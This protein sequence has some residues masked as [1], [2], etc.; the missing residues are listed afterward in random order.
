MEEIWKPIDGYVGKYE[1]SNYGNIRSL[2]FINNVT[3]KEQIHILHP[4]KRN[5]GYMA[6]ML[7]KNGKFTNKLVHRLV[8]EAFIP[9]PHGKKQ[10]NHIDGNKE[11]NSIGNLEWCT[12]SENMTHAFKT[13]LS[14]AQSKGKYGSSNPKAIKVDMIDRKTNQIIRQFGSLIDASHYVGAIKSCHIC[15]CC[16]GKVKSAYGYKWRYAE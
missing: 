14:K 13:G 7:Y 8:A 3:N 5:N 9:N 12:Q 16:K 1:V 4:Q 2:R 6:I 11:N 15:S 10:I